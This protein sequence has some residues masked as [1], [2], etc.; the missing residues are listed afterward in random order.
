MIPAN[1]QDRDCVANLIRTTV[2]C[3]HGSQNFLPMAA[4]LEQ[5]SK[6]PLP[7]NR[8]NGKSSSAGQR[9]RVQGGPP[10]VGRRANL[11]LAATQSTPDAPLQT[12]A[13]IAE[14]YAKLA[15]T[16]IML[17]R[18]ADPTPHR[19]RLSSVWALSPIFG[20]RLRVQVKFDRFA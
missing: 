3:F 20:R 2:V 1:I 12:F 13:F 14:G 7:D 4:K 5:S 10:T 6:R 17:K 15:M 11:I 19:A 9:R 8:S 16:S 18:L